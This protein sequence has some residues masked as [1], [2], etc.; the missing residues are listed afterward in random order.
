MKEILE[1]E[2]ESPSLE[3]EM[4]VIDYFLSKKRVRRVSPLSQIPYAKELLSLVQGDE[5]RA[6]LLI[7]LALKY[8]QNTERHNPLSK[9]RSLSFV[10]DFAK[11]L[12][13]DIL[14]NT[15]KIKE[16]LSAAKKLA[17]ETL[18]E[19]RRKKSEEIIKKMEEMEKEKAD[20]EIAKLY[21]SKIKEL[22]QP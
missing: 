17:K 16:L 22:L 8:F 12:D 6:F 19:Y 4:K 1:H 9:V 13:P 10:L 18:E 3:N 21:I 11:S 15:K 14:S 7:D 20:P 5:K 2:V